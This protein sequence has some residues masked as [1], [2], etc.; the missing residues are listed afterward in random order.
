MRKITSYIE[1]VMTWGG[2]SIFRTINLKLANFPKM[3]E[4]AIE[5]QC[6]HLHV[7]VSTSIFSPTKLCFIC[8]IEQAV[9]FQKLSQ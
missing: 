5:H 6:G 7:N 4:Q 2:G 1:S 8:F 3:P 9:A